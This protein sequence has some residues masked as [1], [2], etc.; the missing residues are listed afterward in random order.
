MAEALSQ[1]Q[2]DELLN[3]MRSGETAH[4]P[5]E[6]E[7]KIKEYDFSS[8]KKFTKDQLK[9]LYSLYEN[10]ARILSSYFTSILRSACEV[11]IS[12]I[13]EQR[14]YEFNNALPDNALIGMISFFPEE[15]PFD[16]TTMMLELSTSF[17][18]LLIDRLMGGSGELYAPDRDYTE[19]ELSLLK[20]VMQSITG[21]MHDVWSSFFANKT[22]LRNVETNGRFIQAFSPQDIVVII[23]FEIDDEYYKGTANICM[24]TANLEEL[25]SSFTMKYNHSSKQ[26]DE[27]KERVKRQRILNSIKES[28]ITLE[29]QLDDCMM[30]LGELSHLQINDVISLNKRINEDITVKVEGI[31]FFRARLGEHDAQKALKIVGPE[32]FATE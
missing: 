27:E 25:I 26:Q 28:E 6:H 31:P 17:G 19:I 10:F 3:R 15:N 14:Y 13:E 21:Y 30:S 12:Q 5:V 29:A 24:P 7:D 22:M 20:M 32:D 1:S 2:I 16:E 11:S 4:V 18:Y 8:P 9:S 23:T